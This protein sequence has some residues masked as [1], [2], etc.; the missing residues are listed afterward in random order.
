LSCGGLLVEV[1]A[2]S[3]PVVREEFVDAMV[4]PAVDLGQ[5]IDDVPP[6]VNARS[7][8]GRHDGH[9]VGQSVST[10][11]G[12]SKQP[13]LTPRS[14]RAQ[15]ALSATVVNLESAVEGN[16]HEQLVPLIEQV[17]DSRIH[18]LGERQELQLLST[19]AKLVQN[20]H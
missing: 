17:G 16:R 18:R 9:S 19:F 5:D 1:I 10:A 4:W 6:G 11:F 14:D 2:A 15:P 7:D 20:G 3:E 13:S 12:S 8:S